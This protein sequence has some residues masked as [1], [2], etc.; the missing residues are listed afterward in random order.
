MLRKILAVVAGLFVAFCLIVVIELVSTL[1]HP[2]PEGLD[3][4][5]AEQFQ[6]HV[7]TLPISAFLLVLTAWTLGTFAGG[8]VAAKIA[9]SH[10]LLFSGV[11]GAFVFAA[12]VFTLLEIPHPLW[13]SITAVLAIPVA[14]FLA[15]RLARPKP[16]SSSLSPL[17]KDRE[18][19]E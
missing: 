7:A 1:L 10:A 9:R 19:G 2:M 8:F 4:A 13:V 3:P 12:T 11:V 5:N 14:A 15:G 18:Q 6:T 17:G 16:V